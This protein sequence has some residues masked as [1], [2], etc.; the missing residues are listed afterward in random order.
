MAEIKSFED[1]NCWK[2]ATEVRRSVMKLIKKFPPEGK[3]AL[4]S[5]M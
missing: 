1:L 3:Y 4:T 2:A 5:D